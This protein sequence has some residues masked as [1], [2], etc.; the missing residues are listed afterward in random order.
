MTSDCV[1]CFN[2]MINKNN[3]CNICKNGVCNTCYMQI[4]QRQKKTVSHKCPFCNNENFKEW[5]DIDKQVIIDYFL[6][7]EDFMIKEIS[8][9]QDIIKSNDIYINSLKKIIKSK[10]DE[11]VINKEFSQEQ[12][13]I[14][15]SMLL[16]F[17]KPIDIQ[18]KMKYKKFYKITYWGL[19]ETEP[20][21]TPQ[22]AMKRVSILWKEYKKSFESS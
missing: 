6:K 1:I 17:P 20:D 7:N 12:T 14:I 18:K 19:R 5:I 10:D 21:I 16:S 13:N 22:E 4:I 3:N 15:N 2:D 9:L 8:K 11:L